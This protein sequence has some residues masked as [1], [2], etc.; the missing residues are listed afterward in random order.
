M[1]NSSDT[2]NSY[3]HSRP[4]KT[5][6]TFLNDF[7]SVALTSLAMK[8]IEKFVMTEVV[9]QSTFG[10]AST[11]IYTKHT[12]SNIEHK[13]VEELVLSV[14]PLFNHTQKST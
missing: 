3:H 11:K 9:K 4:L 10:P 5:N 8:C 12:Y 13:T 1:K 7:R 14:S 6:P 2:E